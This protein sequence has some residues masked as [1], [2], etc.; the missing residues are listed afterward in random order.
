MDLFVR[1]GLVG[2]MI[3]NGWNPIVTD[4]TMTFYKSQSVFDRIRVKSTVTNWDDKYFYSTH[5]IYR[6]DVKVAQGTSKALV[7]NR[8]E[9]R[10]TPDE[11]VEHVDRARNRN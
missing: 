10:L 4:V 7:I 5:A 11:V 3:K 8:K 6:R 1:S 9:G 2:L